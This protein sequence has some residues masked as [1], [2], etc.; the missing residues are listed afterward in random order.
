MEEIPTKVMLLG[1]ILL[2]ILKKLVNLL[3]PLQIMT[4]SAGVYGYAQTRYIDPI[5]WSQDGEAFAFF[6]NINFASAIYA[7]D[8]ISSLSLILLI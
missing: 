8:A 6:G 4:M 5:Q 2:L 3:W 1:K 7:L